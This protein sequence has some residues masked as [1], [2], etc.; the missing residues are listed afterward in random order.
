MVDSLALGL[1][2]VY[3]PESV[4]VTSENFPRLTSAHTRV[5]I[6]KNCSFHGVVVVKRYKNYKEQGGFFKGD[7]FGIFEI[8]PMEG[9][10]LHV[11]DAIEP[12]KPACLIVSFRSATCT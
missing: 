12:L 6:Q 10:F 9:K 4:S 5:F 7:I 1:V 3:L 8:V 2:K 11:V